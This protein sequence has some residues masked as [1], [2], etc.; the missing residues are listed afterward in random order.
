MSVNR[1]FVLKGMALSSIAGLAI[2][3]SVRALAGTTATAPTAN[4]SAPVLVLLN[5]GAA[6]SG[7]LYGTTAASDSQLT[8]QRVGADLGFVLNFERQLRSGQP[9]RVIGLLDDASATLLVDIARSAG[10][11]M[12]WLGQHTA[13]LRFTCHHLLSTALAESCSLQLTR[14]LQACGAGFNL[15]EERQSGLMTSRLLAA[16]TQQDNQWIPSLGYLLA[17]LG[18]DAAVPAPMMPVGSKPL[19]GSFVSFSIEV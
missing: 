11:R 12:Q 1:R 4:T 8:V 18:A 10:A 13:N 3:S 16:P 2:N 19:T 6:E 15:Q 5:E 14:Q 7:F 9:M 17:S